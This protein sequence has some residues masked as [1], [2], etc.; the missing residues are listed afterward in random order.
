M[1]FY[2]LRFLFLYDLYTYLSLPK[3]MNLEHLT[4]LEVKKIL[5]S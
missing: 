4:P 5:I 2:Y 3:I 1:L